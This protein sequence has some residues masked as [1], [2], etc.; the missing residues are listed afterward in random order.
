MGELGVKKNKYVILLILITSILAGCN[1]VNQS[2]PNP[3]I[4]KRPVTLD[5]G[6]GKLKT[7]PSYD[8]YQPGQL[9]V[10]LR[11][12]D[13][14][15]LD[16]KERYEDLIHA[17]FDTTTKWPYG[18]PDKFNPKKIIEYG[19]NPGLNIR[20][21]HKSGITGKGVGI[22]IIDGALLVN[23]VEY[24]DKLKLYE[25]IH[26]L[27]KT[28]MPSG[29]AVVSTVAGEKTGVAPE[30]NIYYI[31]ETHGLTAQGTSNVDFSSLAVAINRIVKINDTLSKEDKIR[32]LVIDGGWTQSD[33]GYNAINKTVEE[34]KEKGIFVI[35]NS[36]YETYNQEMDFSGLGR[37]PLTNPD[38]TS[39][40]GPGEEW[41]SRFFMFEKYSNAKEVLLVPMDSRCTASPT[42]DS[43]YAF[44]NVGGNKLSAAYI[45]GLYALACQVRPEITPLEFWHTALKTG[46]T[47]HIKNKFINYDYKLK[48]VVNPVQLVNE[49]MK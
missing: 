39:S 24:K 26:C 45:A 20:E 10:D 36:I 46:D 5:L 40:Y 29:C 2:E 12:Y 11:S 43:D 18:L 32:A 30:S 7:L 38:D 16:L 23:H 41:K 44:Y 17:D 1:G 49:L 8:K 28:A 4:T 42:G 21:L 13:L 37:N 15:T 31:A 34:A 6:R 35:S 14:T 22:A 3:E 19:K 27:D 33:N 48:K 25:E 47:V 9:Q